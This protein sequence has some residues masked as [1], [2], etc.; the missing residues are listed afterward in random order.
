MPFTVAGKVAGETA[1]VN[2]PV[3]AFCFVLMGFCTSVMWSVIF[4]LSTE[5]VGKYTE[6]AAGFFMTMVVGGGVLPLL[7]SFIT[8][9]VG[10]AVSFIVPAACLAYLFVYALAFSKNVHTDLKVD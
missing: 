3:G 5:G 4:N 6:Q 8:D 7:Q 1:T 2:V 9:K 10:F